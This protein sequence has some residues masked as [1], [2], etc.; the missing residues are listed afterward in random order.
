MLDHEFV[1]F[2]S[3]LPA[4]FK[5]QGT[6]KKVILKK[7][8]GNLL[9]DKIFS[10]PKHGFEVPLQ[11]WLTNSLSSLL[12]EYTQKSFVESQG[13]FNYQYITYLKQK[14]KSIN[15]G[16]SGSHLWNILVF[17]YWWKKTYH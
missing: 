12:D 3:T 6:N 14:L 10:K 16:D 8:F 15:P 17:Q 13:I 1:N 2:I 9:P 7:A 4:H 5:I 11:L